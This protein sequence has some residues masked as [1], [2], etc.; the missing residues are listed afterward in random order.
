MGPAGALSTI[1]LA[2]RAGEAQPQLEK[3]LQRLC[4]ASRAAW[5]TI[6]LSDDAFVSALGRRAG[7]AADPVAAVLALHTSDLYLAC[8]AAACNPA[9]L[10]AFER[11][12][13]PQIERAVASFDGGPSLASE[14]RQVLRERFFLDRAAGPPAVASYSGEAPLAAWVR[15][16]AVR[17]AARLREERQRSAGA[18]DAEL[19]WLADASSDPELRLL[20]ETYRRELRE[21]VHAA[22]GALSPRERNLLRLHAVDKLT[23]GQIAAA[24]GVSGPT[25]SRWLQQAREALSAGTRQLLRSR[26]SLSAAQIESLYGLVQSQLDLSL[27]R[28]LG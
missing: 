15:A 4:A 7:G 26:L 28:V 3:T 25:I 8:A 24:Y 6:E 27:S 23:G 22:L 19:E 11:A 10:E 17:A 1:F 16:G 21:A 5:P 9:A 14:V 2:N 20:K 12:F 13:F 18:G